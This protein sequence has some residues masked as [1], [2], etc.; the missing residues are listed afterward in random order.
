MFQS[1]KANYALSF[2]CFVSWVDYRHYF[3]FYFLGNQM[4]ELYIFLTVKTHPLQVIV[5]GPSNSMLFPGTFP[6]SFEHL[7]V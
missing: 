2:S 3:E 5:L 1:N 6:M 7:M 4:I